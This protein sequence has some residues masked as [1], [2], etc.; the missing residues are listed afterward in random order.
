MRISRKWIRSVRGRLSQAAFAKLIGVHSMT[1]TKWEIGV[2]KPEGATITLLR[3][4]YEHPR[5]LKFL[6]EWSD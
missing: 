6:R 2:C 4:L 1:V 3:L 5:L